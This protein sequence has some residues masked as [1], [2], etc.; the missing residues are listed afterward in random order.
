MTTST[1]RPPAALRPHESRDC[2]CPECK[3]HDDAACPPGMRRMPY[4]WG[5]AR[6]KSDG[7]AIFF[8]ARNFEEADKFTQA[9]EE[10]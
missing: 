5:G 9:I 6:R 4:V 3:A 7:V 1:T 8:V 2:A 10:S